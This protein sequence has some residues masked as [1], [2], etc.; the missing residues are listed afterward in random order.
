MKIVI[1]GAGA[2]G[3]IFGAMLQSVARV[4]LVDR[5]T[6]HLKAVQAQGLTIEDAAGNRRLLRVETTTEPERLSPDFDLAIVFTKSYDTTGA[7]RTA[8]TLLTANGLA[9]TLQNGVGNLDVLLSE[10]GP[11]R[12][13]AGVTSHGGT[14]VEPGVVRHAGVGPTLL[15]AP[16][17]ATDLAPVADVFNRAGIATTVSP[18]L[19]RVIW[20]KLVVNV[21]INALAAILRVPNGVLGEEPA[22]E[23]LMAAAVGEAVAV[24]K[25]S[26][27]A[28]PYDDPLAHVKKVCAD[29]G[30]N[31]AS[32]LQDVLAGARTEIGVINR[33]ILDR[34]AALGVPTPVNRLLTEI[35]TALE[36]TRDRRM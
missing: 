16:S 26:G 17:P 32:M 28:L 13:A 33:A 18:E 34:G 30:P 9:L 20:G 12:A 21:G 5:I 6:P 36:A 1:I 2:M 25:A 8:R 35:V 19:D 15:G 14:L 22:C 23:V 11:G 31:R 27:I 29:T 4:T 3:S 7:A 24:A 10:V